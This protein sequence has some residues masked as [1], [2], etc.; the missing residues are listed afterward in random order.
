MSTRDGPAQVSSIL[1]PATVRSRPLFLHFF[2]VHF[3]E[4]RG[5]FARSPSALKEMDLATRFAVMVGSRILVPASSYYESDVAATV[6]KPFLDSKYTS[7]RFA[8]V[9]SGSSIEEFRFEKLPQYPEGSPQYAAYLVAQDYAIGWYRRQR[10]AGR[11]IARGWSAALPDAL[12]AFH[13]FYAGRLA[14][15]VFERQWLQVEERLGPSAWIVPHVLEN[16]DVDR[17]SLLVRNRLHDIINREY[18]LS[19]SSDPGVGMIQGLV[20]LSSVKLPTQ[21]PQDDIWFDLL[22]KGCRDTG[23]LRDIVEA[24][25]DSLDAL[26]VDPR[27][28]NAFENTQTE[29]YATLAPPTKASVDL[30]IV[31]ALP[32]EREAVEQVFGAGV[33]MRIRGDNHM[34][35]LVTLKIREET[36]KVVYA[37]SDQGNV[38]AAVLATNMLRSFDVRY[39][40]FVGIAGGCPNPVKPEDHVRLGDVVISTKVVEHD[41]FKLHADGTIE[42]RDSPQRASLAW[43]QTAAS[44]KSSAMGFSEDWRGAYGTAMNGLRGQE[45]DPGLD[46]LHDYDGK[47]V[48]HPDDPR[49]EGGRPIVH[50]GVIAAGDTLLKDPRRRDAIRDAFSALAIEMEAAGLRDAAYAGNIEFVVV[51]GIVDYCDTF[52]ADDYRAKASVSAAAVLK[53]LFETLVVAEM[54]GTG[55]RSPIVGI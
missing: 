7:Q 47:P 36:F 23:V 43:T 42:T 14:E 40:A 41:H 33:P 6:L 38:R 24:D 2:D 11:D 8:L 28:T 10:S 53:L 4:E 30:A 12:R 45:P 44:L 15:A 27:F 54:A 32:I 31:T 21:S 50:T 52:K 22:L 51:R 13:P 1:K 17:T 18:I 34:Y 55:F 46:K 39:A 26:S 29:G 20:K 9:G 25:P 5:R 37:S 16:L 3:I 19:Y 35:R 48:S 49:R